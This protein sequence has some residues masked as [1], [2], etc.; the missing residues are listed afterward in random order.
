MIDH[1]LLDWGYG[2]G[3]YSN[4]LRMYR[5]QPRTLSKMTIISYIGSESSLYHLLWIVW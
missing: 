5:V 2:A 1:A 4:M 3:A